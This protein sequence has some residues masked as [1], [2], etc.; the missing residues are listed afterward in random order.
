VVTLLAHVRCTPPETITTFGV[1][2]LAAALVVRP[3]RKTTPP[4]TRQRSLLALV[5]ALAIVGV[6]C[7]GGSSSSST[8][9][10]AAAARPTT[11]AQIKIT[12][13]TPNQVS[14]PDVV[15]KVELVGGS[16]VQRT[17]GKLTPTEGHVHL[18]LDGK[19]V[20]MAYTTEQTLPGIAP[21][22]HAI[23]AEFVA[24]DHAPFKNRQKAAVLFE[25]KAP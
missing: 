14:P 4:R 15:V 21:G 13:P 10:T 16:V 7:G 18:T 20:S 24:V 9:T 3:W 2:A 17:T 12:A 23:E 1:G 5:L 22:Q 6:G 19:L 8:T 25:V 11:T